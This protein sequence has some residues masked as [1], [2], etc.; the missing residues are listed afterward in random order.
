MHARH[1]VVYA[2]ASTD[3]IDDNDNN[4]SKLEIP[5]DATRHNK[6]TE[7]Q[8]VETAIENHL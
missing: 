4:Y 7:E 8:L 3:D 1:D 6:I 5:N 2:I